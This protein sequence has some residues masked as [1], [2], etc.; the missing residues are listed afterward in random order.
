MHREQGE[1][2]TLPQFLANKG[3]E[4]KWRGGGEWKKVDKME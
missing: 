4:L 2:V 3:E 1:L